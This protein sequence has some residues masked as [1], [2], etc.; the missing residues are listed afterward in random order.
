[1]K[2]LSIYAL[3]YLLT[4]VSVTNPALLTSN[5]GFFA[6]LLQNSTTAAWVYTFLNSWNIRYTKSHQINV[7][8]V[9][10]ILFSYLISMDCTSLLY[11]AR[12]LYYCALVSLKTVF[13]LLKNRFSL[14]KTMF[15]LLKSKEIQSYCK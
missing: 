9:T 5:D 8:M 4:H 7:K 2:D 11:I 3:L 12:W 1:M 14:L 6:V 15:S 13:S 10:L